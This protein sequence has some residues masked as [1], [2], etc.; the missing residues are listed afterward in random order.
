MSIFP[1][2]KNFQA[3]SYNKAFVLN[4][5]AGA[6]VFVIYSKLRFMFNC[7]FDVR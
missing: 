7:I 5:I 3:T 6:L 4:A 1:L 2:I